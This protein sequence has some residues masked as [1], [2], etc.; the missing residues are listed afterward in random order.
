MT[1]LSD[2]HREVILLRLYLGGEWD[3]VAQEMG[4]ADNVHATQELYR[5]ARKKLEEK[6]GPKLGELGD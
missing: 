3:F 6:L 5:R 4:R 2:D 1:D